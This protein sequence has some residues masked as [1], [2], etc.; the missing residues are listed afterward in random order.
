MAVPVVTAGPMATAATAAGVV[1]VR[2]A[3]PET[4]ACCPVPM[5]ATAVLVVW[6]VPAV[7]VAGVARSPVMVV[8][9]GPPVPAV[10]AGPAAA[11]RT[12]WP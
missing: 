9:A 10:S 5:A 1:A 12:V 3:R 11:A 7:P 6:V 8:T 2:W 4:T